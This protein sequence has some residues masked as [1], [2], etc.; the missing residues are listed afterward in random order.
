MVL[1]RR[2][3]IHRHG[4]KPGVHSARLPRS[5]G[6]ERKNSTTPQAGPN[7]RTLTRHDE[8]EAVG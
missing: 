5:S 3:W 6:T 4:K 1:V 8:M 2:Q 7:I